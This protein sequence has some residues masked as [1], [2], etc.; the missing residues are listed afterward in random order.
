VLFK[1]CSSIALAMATENTNT[2]P[3]DRMMQQTLPRVTFSQQST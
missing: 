2:E 3:L 1:H